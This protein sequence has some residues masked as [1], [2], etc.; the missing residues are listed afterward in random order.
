MAGFFSPVGFTE[1][2]CY[3]STESE[4]RA[5]KAFEEAK[6]YWPD[7][8]ERS[9]QAALRAIKIINKDNKKLKYTKKCLTRTGEGAYASVTNTGCIA[10]WPY[11]PHALIKKIRSQYPP[12]PVVTLSVVSA[13]SGWQGDV[14]GGSSSVILKVKNQG[15]SPLS[16]F[17]IGNVR[18]QG[19]S[20][21]GR[22]F[23]EVAAQ[24]TVLI[25]L[26]NFRGGDLSVTAT[27]DEE[28]GFTGNPSLNF[29][30]R[31]L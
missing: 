11:T 9:E 5:I 7:D 15:Q 6:D 18:F 14:E 16:N 19:R 8:W 12:R 20:I 17:S 22:L 26:G 28:Y 25:D 24:E 29:S 27:F 3:E 1:V 4:C 31:G 13:D 23:E 10:T 2:K 21:P 30:V